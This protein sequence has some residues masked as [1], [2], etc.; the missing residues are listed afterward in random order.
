PVAALQWGMLYHD[1]LDGEGMF[2]DITSYH[3][4]IAF[5]LETLEKALRLVVAA[6]P[7][8]RTSIHLL[9]YG[10]PLQIVHRDAEMPL[11]V[12]D[13]SSQPPAEQERTVLGWID[14]ERQRPFRWDEPP[15]VR[16]H[17]HRRSPETVQLT[18]SEHHAVLDGWSMSS[19]L[20]E[21]LQL[22]LR[23]LDGGEV[24]SPAA[25]VAQMRDFV[26][27]EWQA[28]AN[29]AA[30][31][32]WR[33]RVEAAP[34]G[35][36]PAWLRPAPGEPAPPLLQ[37][38]LFIPPPVADGLR[39][40]ADRVRVPLRS[41]LLAAHLRVVSELLGS[42]AVVSGCVTH[43]RPEG[44]DGHRALGLFLN[45]VP[46]P[47]ELAGGSWSDLASQVYAAE[48]ALRP[49][50]HYPMAYM[51]RW[52]REPLFETGFNFI[53]FHVEEALRG[54]SGVEFLGLRTFEDTDLHLFANFIPVDGGAT[55]RLLL[56]THGSEVGEKQA[57]AVGALYREVLERMA[58]DPEAPHGSLGESLLPWR[59][60][61][62]VEDGSPGGAPVTWPD[63]S[64]HP[65]A[66]ADAAEE[67]LA[68]IWCE[69]LGR[70]Q[71]GAED[72][73][74]AVGGHSLAALQICLAV[75]ERLGIPVALADLLAASTVRHQAE[76]LLAVELPR[77]AA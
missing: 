56:N 1:E 69:V 63:A 18:I 43:G 74:F 10:E 2:R 29:T 36:L 45:T 44:A 21:L 5:D 55:L 64:R 54:L 57:R 15:L 4:R 41:V 71:I 61:P 9:G 33:G 30:E 35:L 24:A 22:Y 66:P 65:E 32:F 12:E 26:A 49:H 52:R 8:L 13:I 37:Q 68:A 19:L 11:T 73:F 34:R 53:D 28:L 75:R 3:L 76:T 59:E 27:L 14:A 60:R 16:L 47:L 6:H 77:P 42:P 20:T 72:D 48:L 50:R 25:P 62:M 7:I 51:R 31:D 40:L 67:A 58:A 39:A 17:I 38:L 23:L 46:F 70:E